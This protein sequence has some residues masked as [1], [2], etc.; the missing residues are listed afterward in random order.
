MARGRRVCHAAP[1]RVGN[2]RFRVHEPQRLKSIAAFRPKLA[3]GERQ[4]LDRRPPKPLS[5]VR[6]ANAR[7]QPPSRVLFSS[8]PKFKLMK[9]IPIITFNCVFSFFL[10]IINVFALWPSGLRINNHDASYEIPEND[11]YIYKSY[12]WPVEYA[13]ASGRHSHSFKSGEPSI[14]LFSP[15]VYYRYFYVYNAA[16][17]V[18]FAFVLTIGVFLAIKN[19]DDTIR[20]SISL[21]EFVCIITIVAFCFACACEP[22][23]AYQYI[24]SGLILL[25]IYARVFVLWKNPSYKRRRNGSVEN[26]PP[27]HPLA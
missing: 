10:L 13:L 27:V 9:A 18:T 23:H 3:G 24:Y 17:D 11:I 14:F 26:I 20:A 22:S 19:A 1:G 5:F 6:T 16:F 21:S 2:A 4:T 25:V 12:G 7:P 15:D 8:F